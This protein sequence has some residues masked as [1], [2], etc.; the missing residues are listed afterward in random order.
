MKHT[1]TSAG[2]FRP[3]G[4]RIVTRGGTLLHLLFSKGRGNHQWVSSHMA[5][6]CRGQEF[7][8]L[9]AFCDESLCHLLLLIYIFSRYLS[10]NEPSLTFASIS[11][12]SHSINGYLKMVSYTC[13]W[14]KAYQMCV[15]IVQKP[16][17][18]KQQRRLCKV[19]GSWPAGDVKVCLLG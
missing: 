18:E 3:V 5:R 19:A 9:G 16:E 4:W 13:S 11:L 10:L 17:Q 1:N 7:M 6:T 12:L 8:L 2:L 14:S 15:R